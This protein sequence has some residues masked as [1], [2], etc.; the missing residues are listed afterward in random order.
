MLASLNCDVNTKKFYLK[1]DSLPIF[2]TAGKSVV[3]YLNIKIYVNIPYFAIFHPN[4]YIDLQWNYVELNTSDCE[5]ISSKLLF[6]H[7]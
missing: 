3:S 7:N 6:K 2:F 1:D 4:K 5:P